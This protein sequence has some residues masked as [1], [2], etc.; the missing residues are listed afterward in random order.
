MLT[1]IE[2]E[3]YLK[4]GVELTPGAWGQHS[5]S[6]GTNA[7][8]IAERVPEMDSDMAY[9][10]G[11]M[12]DIGRRVGI[13][14]IL[15]IF[16]GYDFMMSLGQEELA[17]ICLTHSF[18]I[19]DASTF[20]GKYDCTASQ[21]VFLENFLANVQ[22]D[23]YDILIQ[24]CDAISLPNGACIMEKRLID[25]ALRHGLPSFTIDKWKA[26]MQTKKYF[27]ELCNC[28]I[29]ELLPNVFE[30]SLSDLI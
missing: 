27:D 23:N 28:N 13:K 18:P 2:A 14:G 29:Y 30:N 17:R 16:D 1:I 19:K 3:N 25:V 9:I 24:L 5:I 8:L 26:F 6:V 20:F 12:H 21:I 7:R 15:H 11:L 4:I 22:Y 10:M